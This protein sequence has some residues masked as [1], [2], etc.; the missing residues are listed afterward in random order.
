MNNYDN[1]SLNRNNQI[2]ANGFTAA[3]GSLN[4][5]T[6]VEAT[7]RTDY[8]MGKYS[9]TKYTTELRS[10]TVSLKSDFSPSS[11]ADEAGQKVEGQG[12]GGLTNP[13]G[14]GIRNDSQGQGHW[15]ASR[16]SRAHKG[17]DFAT[18][19]G[20]DIYSP[21]DGR[22]VYAT[23]AS[24]GARVDIYPSNPSAAGFTMIRMLYVDRPA[25]INAWSSVNVTAGTPIGI[26]ADLQTRGYS[27]SVT[28]HIHFQIQNGLL[29]NGQP[30]WI[31]PTPFFPGLR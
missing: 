31:N 12:G 9:M 27:P 24:K 19:V 6:F 16:G 18:T 10:A 11:Q 14:Q 8:K 17:L 13:T 2:A 30:N 4:F 3:D 28:P 29:P 23:G 20:Q 15:G 22:V 1:P 7:Y 26:A 25:G 21:V 5:E